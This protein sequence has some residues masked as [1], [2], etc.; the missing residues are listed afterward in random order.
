MRPD[1]PSGVLE[2]SMTPLM[3]LGKSTGIVWHR[4][5]KN[6]VQGGGSAHSR[7]LY[8]EYLCSGFPDS[9]SSAAD[10]R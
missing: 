8:P 10:T 3:A 4:S 2:D 5:S 1:T 6:V 7:S 9:E